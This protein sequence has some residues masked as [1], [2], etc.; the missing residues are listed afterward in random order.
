MTDK[1]VDGLSKAL[2]SLK[3]GFHIAKDIAK[4]REE[5]TKLA[6]EETKAAAGGNLLATSQKGVGTSANIMAAGET[7]AGLATKGLSVAMKGL[8]AAL[9]STGIGIL[10]AALGELVVLL[11][12]AFSK[13]RQARIEAINAASEN[14]ASTV[15]DQINN[16]DKL[17]E[18]R[19]FDRRKMEAAGATELELLEKKKEDLEDLSFWYRKNAEDAQ[20]FYETEKEKVDKLSEE[21]QEEHAE[22]LK[23]LKEAADLAAESVDNLD[24]EIR[25]TDQDIEVQKIK[26]AHDKLSE[27]NNELRKWSDLVKDQKFQSDWKALF[28]LDLGGNSPVE[29]LQK[30]KEAAIALVNQYKGDTKEIEQFFNQAIQEAE[31]EWQSLVDKEKEIFDER[32]TPAQRLENEK[33]EWVAK[34]EKWGMDAVEITRYYDKKIQEELD[35]AAEEKKQKEE[36]TENERLDKLGKFMNQV[37]SALQ[38]QEKMNELFN[39]VFET[40]TVA[41]DIQQDIDRVQALY[42]TQMNY[43]NGLLESAE[44]VEGAYEEIES[45]ILELTVTFNKQMNEL[46]K[47]Q[48]TQGKNVGIFSAKWKASLGN[49]EAAAASFSD[50]WQTMGLE[51]STAFKGFATAQAVISSLLA[52][53]RVLAEEPGLAITKAIAA[54]GILAA[55]L[56][57][58][59]AIWAVDPNGSN[60]G[61]AMNASMQQPAV[62]VIGNSQP[63]NY[64]RNITTAEEE[65]QMNQPIYVTVTDIEDGING[66]RAQVTNSSF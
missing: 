28:E 37:D 3:D 46:K 64:T 52:A 34:A 13:A 59:A 39:P 27:T 10:I 66:H 53:N 51:D 7:K 26:D 8:K 9:I 48:D 47:E 35:R 36:D 50:A 4:S 2:K 62:P 38:T 12:K 20:R 32:L 29:V 43:L 19:E 17:T 40:K 41:D 49:M 33:A 15:T 22:A 11:D 31:A 23:K 14:L 21:R 57:N 65:D 60:A 16:L 63:I 18:E 1:Q 25:R 55:G 30:Q 54:A 58:V 56:A 5:T 44:L 61:S 45:R 24:E 42:D 6:T